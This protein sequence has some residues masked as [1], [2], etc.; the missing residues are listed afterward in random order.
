MIVKEGTSIAGGKYIVEARLGKG[1]QAEVWK[2]QQLGVGGFSKDVVIKIVH[3]KALETPKLHE[4]FLNEAHL[5]AQ[6]QHPNVVEI[7]D[8][9]QHNELDYIVMELIRGQDLGR[10]LEDHVQK[11]GQPLPWTLVA[12]MMIGVCKGLFYA[13]TSVGRDGK[14]LDLI[15]RDL[16]PENMLLT[17]DGFIKI[18][19]FGMAKASSVQ[20]KTQTGVIKG[21]PSYMSPEQITAR[22]QD[23]RSDL[24]ALGI[25]MYELCTGQRPFLG[26]MLPTL[27]YAILEN[28]P[29]P[30]RKR[31]PRIPASFD[32]LV[33]KLLEKKPDDRFQDARQVQRALE[34]IIR[35]DA[36]SGFHRDSLL[37]FA[38]RYAQPNPLPA[39]PAETSQSEPL[40]ATDA[41]RPTYTPS[42]A[43]MRMFDSH[44][45][46]PM[47]QPPASLDTLFPEDD[48][49][50][51]PT[52]AAP[53]EELRKAAQ[54]RPSSEE[55]RTT[56]S[57]EAKINLPSHLPP[58]AVIG[59]PTDQTLRDS[60]LPSAEKDQLR[61]S[62]RNYAKEI[63][64][65]TPTSASIPSP[66]TRP[67]AESE[68]SSP[69]IS[70]IIAVSTLPPHL[71]P[72]YEHSRP[73]DPN[74]HLPNFTSEDTEYITDAQSSDAQLPLPPSPLASPLTSAPLTSA[75]PPTAPAFSPTAPTLPPTASTRSSSSLFDAPPPKTASPS[76][77][78]LDA[79]SMN[80]KPSNDP[81]SF[82]DD[83]SDPFLQPPEQPDALG[84]NLSLA[85]PNAAP[86]LLSSIPSSDL[87][88][89]PI[90]PIG[91]IAPLSQAAQDPQ[92]STPND[93]TLTSVLAAPDTDAPILAPSAKAP[94]PLADTSDVPRYSAPSLQTPLTQS[95]SHLLA[96]TLT[97][98]PL[99]KLGSAELPSLLPPLGPAPLPASL[100]F[101][102]SAE[103]PTPPHKLGSAELPTPLPSPV[104]PEPRPNIATELAFQSTAPLIEGISPEVAA[105]LLAPNTSPPS[106]GIDISA[107][108]HIT[109]VRPT[110]NAAHTSSKSPSPSVFSSLFENKDYDAEDEEHDL[111]GES[112]SIQH[113]PQADTPQQNAEDD[114]P[115]EAPTNISLSPKRPSPYEDPQDEVIF[116]DIAFMSQGELPALSFHFGDSPSPSRV[117]EE[118]ATI[119][120]GVSPLA[121]AAYDPNQPPPEYYR[122]AQAAPPRVVP[123][124][125]PIPKPRDPDDLR[126]SGGEHTVLDV[127]LIETIQRRKQRIKMLWIGGNILVIL[128]LVG[129]ILFLTLR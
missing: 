85:S 72:T 5:A 50:I 54:K 6:L 117:D 69:I 110:Q 52:M 111:A 91:P 115:D 12:Q 45:P 82:L 28:Q 37:Q 93:P 97:Q 30:L 102:G 3:A 77:S 104:N 106:H 13:H 48:A 42:P 76:S 64:P 66:S 27:I 49:A 128:I 11:T 96:S 126:D 100:P 123:Q 32:Q 80:V 98:S 127:R 116:S 79:L 10:I 92:A 22:P 121:G 78:L 34:Q 83:F 113:A 9:G 55:H 15:H 90:N 129:I 17:V 73:T 71:L 95:H 4:I 39:P 109:H 84:F 24:F 44:T 62:L 119:R 103:L 33:L 68:S 53:L 87:P 35:Q 67:T 107:A 61:H 81:L 29:E 99:H 59:I 1:G 70:K 125:L 21:T 112:T 18:I 122:L 101:L 75:L 105:A 58:G 114:D 38:Q 47:R 89:N 60:V 19:D 88:I 16:K 51:E 86:T 63:N 74:A 25:I 46:N 14:P 8:I 41:T 2:A 36:P 20:H 65:P 40:I 57:K 108:Y 43:P 94:D 120:Q 118:A 56:P 7:Y 23:L 26:D 124:N 31:S